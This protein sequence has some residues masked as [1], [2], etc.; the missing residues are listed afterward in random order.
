MKIPIS[1]LFIGGLSPT[2]PSRLKK[3]RASADSA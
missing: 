1:S 2:V 3:Q